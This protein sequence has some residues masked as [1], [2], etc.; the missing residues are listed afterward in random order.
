MK[1]IPLYNRD[2]YVL[3][4]EEDYEYLSQFR[5]TKATVGYARRNYKGGSIYMHR[6]IMGL[7]KGDG[8]Y[9]DH[10][11]HNKLDN[12]KSNLRVCDKTQNQINQKAKKKLD[13]SSQSK[14]K[15]VSLR[16]KNRGNKP[17][18]C[19]IAY[20]GKITTKYFATEKEAALAYN[21][22]AKEI[23]GEYAF[24]NDVK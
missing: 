11:N 24:L 4:D 1:K 17:W 13:G 2:E 21:E 19:R 18:R 14:Y 9:V 7:V 5:W 23:H 10:M 20:R 8:K 12:R 3:V 6:E 22:L 15:G 16:P